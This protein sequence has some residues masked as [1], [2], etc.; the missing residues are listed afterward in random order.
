[1][2]YIMEDECIFVSSR[3][4]LKS[5][6]IHSPNPT[7][8]GTALGDVKFPKNPYPPMHKRR[9]LDII[10]KKEKKK[11]LIYICSAA[12]PTFIKYIF[13]LLTYSFVLISGDSDMCCPNHLSPK[14]DLS[15]FIND[16]RIIKW[17]ATKLDRSSTPR[18]FLCP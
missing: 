4:I 16:E 13:P 6:H 14:T 2:I 12:I 18:Y 9:M 8:D 5:C 10:A 7:S 15:K 11:I 1:M 17:Y 3:G